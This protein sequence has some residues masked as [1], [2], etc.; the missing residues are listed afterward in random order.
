M[1]TQQRIGS[2][3]TLK[4]KSNIKSGDVNGHLHGITPEAHD[5]AQ[6]KVNYDSLAKENTPHDT[7]HKKPGHPFRKDRVGVV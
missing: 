4:T 6:V 2:A 7:T 3:G 5:L 1:S